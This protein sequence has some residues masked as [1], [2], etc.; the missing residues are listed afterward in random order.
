MIPL[1]H[2]GYHKTGTSWMQ[3]RLFVPEHGFAP[4]FDHP[5]IDALILQP[6][7][8]AFDAEGLRAEAEARHARLGAHLVPVISSEI[9]SGQP[10]TGGRDSRMVADRLKQAFPEAKIMISIREQ[11]ALLPSLYM[12]YL[13]AGGTMTA[14]KFFAGRSVMGNFGFDPAFHEYH[15]LVGHYAGLFGAANVMVHP[16]EMLIK[17]PGAIVVGL[18]RLTGAATQAADVDFSNATYGAKEFVVPVIRRINHFRHND[19][20]HEPMISFGGLGWLAYRAVNKFSR[21]GIGQRISKGRKPVSQLVDARF[22][23][24][25]DASNAQLQKFVEV[26]LAD[27]GYAVARRADI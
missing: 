2:P 13:Q 8:F 26:D 22:R 9:M 6:G 3:R 21:S 17:D 5:E 15:H 7:P 25:Y 19:F 11:L 1:L 4:L 10:Y 16:M 24:F 20:D 12:Q 27:L 14:Q 18:N 23:G